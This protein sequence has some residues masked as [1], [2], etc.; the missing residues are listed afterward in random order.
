M[1]ECDMILVPHFAC[2]ILIV[3]GQPQQ[4]GFLPQCNAVCE[5]AAVSIR[6]VELFGAVLELCT[7]FMKYQFDSRSGDRLY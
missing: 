5:R 6:L 2:H 1:T 3:M 7:V 4:M